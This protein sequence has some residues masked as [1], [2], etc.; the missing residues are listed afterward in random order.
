MNI[1]KCVKGIKDGRKKEW[2]NLGK[3]N[4]NRRKFKQLEKE[5]REMLKFAFRPHRYDSITN[6]QIIENY[7]SL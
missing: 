1:S 4:C 7:N 3:I 5:H 2:E 6:D